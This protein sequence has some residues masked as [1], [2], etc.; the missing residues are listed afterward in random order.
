MGCS[1][2]ARYGH[3]FVQEGVPSNAA[4]CPLCLGSEARLFLTAQRQHPDGSELGNRFWHLVSSLL[5]AHAH[6]LQHAALLQAAPHILSFNHLPPWQGRTRTVS[7]GTSAI[8][9]NLN[10]VPSWGTVLYLPRSSQGFCARGVSKAGRPMPLS[11]QQ[12]VD[13]G[14]TGKAQ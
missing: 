10:S 5:L 11:R 12:D 13:E 1:T 14:C 4:L 8:C 3:Q 6:I 7:K 9:E 2:V